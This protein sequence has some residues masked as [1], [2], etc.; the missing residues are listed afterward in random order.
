MTS[1]DHQ[2]YAQVGDRRIPDADQWEESIRHAGHKIDIKRAAGI[3]AGDQHVYS[4]Q[5]EGELPNQDTLL[6]L[7]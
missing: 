2:L 3:I 4:R 6:K 5:L 7:G 1:F